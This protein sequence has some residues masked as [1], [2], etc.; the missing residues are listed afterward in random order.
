MIEP[1]RLDVTKRIQDR[2]LEMIRTA[3]PLITSNIRDEDVIGISFESGG[4]G[5]DGSVWNMR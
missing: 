3:L 2:L 4:Y 1:Y 5:C